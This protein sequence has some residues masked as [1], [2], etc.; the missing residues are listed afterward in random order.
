MFPI[1]EFSLMLAFKINSRCSKNFFNTSPLGGLES[2]VLGRT[3]SLKAEVTIVFSILDVIP[4]FTIHRFVA[5][6]TLREISCGEEE[7]GGG[8]LLLKGCSVKTT[9]ECFRYLYENF[10]R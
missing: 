2:F 7:G 10:T 3:D 9:Q 4:Y 5:K 1:V 6:S 8:G